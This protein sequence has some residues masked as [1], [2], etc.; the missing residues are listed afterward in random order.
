MIYLGIHNSWQSGAALIVN[1][2]VVGAVSEERFNRIKN[3][4]GMPT[5]SIR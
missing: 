4:H 1:G 3:F 2:K 5:Q